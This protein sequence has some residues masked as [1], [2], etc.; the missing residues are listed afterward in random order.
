MKLKVLITSNIPAPYFVNYADELGKYVDLTV[1]F[2]LQNAVDR[3][4]KWKNQLDGKHF[5]YHI[6]NAKRFIDIKH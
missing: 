4:E 6:L 3:D 2:E 5:D 1:V